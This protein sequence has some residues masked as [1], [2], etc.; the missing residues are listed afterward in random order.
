MPSSLTPIRRLALLAPLA[1]LAFCACL[2][3]S[4]AGVT[5]APSAPLSPAIQ[6]PVVFDL[7]A[8][9]RMIE[10][11]FD[12]EG[13]SLNAVVYEPQGAGPH[14]ALV[15]LHGFPGFERNLDLAQAARRA[16]WTVVFFHYRGS[17][18]SGCLLY[19]SPSPRDATLSRMPSS[20]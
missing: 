6:D 17:W 15:L 7:D 19:T 16:G 10:T 1:S 4:P 18:G 13:A 3:S 11:A 12:V 5:N 20:A 9:P 14:P 2:T 8:P